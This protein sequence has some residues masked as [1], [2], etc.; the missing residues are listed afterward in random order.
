MKSGKP[1]VNDKPFVETHHSPRVS[2]RLF[3]TE[4]L[5]TELQWHFDLENRWVTPLC[6]NDWYVQ[7][8]NELPA[9]FTTTIFI[10]KG[11]YHRIIKGTTDLL[12]KVIKE[13]L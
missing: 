2:T 13:T 7:L 3:T 11:V 1:K 4:V 8:D 9:P 6:A 12:V 5:E 10:P